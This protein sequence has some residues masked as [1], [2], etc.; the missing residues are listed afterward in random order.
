MYT[1]ACSP[2]G[3]DDCDFV[4]MDDR[5]TVATEACV[6]EAIRQVGHALQD[7]ASTSTYSDCPTSERRRN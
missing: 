3:D 6:L 2:D 1:N 5:R 4:L 7:Q